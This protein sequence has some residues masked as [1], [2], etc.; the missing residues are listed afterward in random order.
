MTNHERI[1]F[2]GGTGGC[3][4]VAVRQVL[5]KGIPV[6]IYTRKPEESEFQGNPNVILVKGDYT[7]YT[8]Y[9]KSIAG[10]TR[11]FLLV[12]SLSGMPAIK[13]KLAKI[14][15]ASG[16][17]QIVD[18][19]SLTINACAW[20]HVAHQ[21]LGGEEAIDALPERKGRSYVRLRPWRF[22][23]NHFHIKHAI[24][25]T[26][27]IV[28]V[29]EPDV[30]QGWISPND[31]GLLAAIVL[32]DPFEKHADGIYLMVGY[33]YTPAERAQILSK[34]LGKPIVY[35]K[36]SF[37]EQYGIFTNVVGFPHKISYDFAA[38]IYPDPH[39]SP[40]LSLALGREPETLEQW[41]E[42]NKKHF[43]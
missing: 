15:Y 31:I 3:G 5:E 21:H 8:P 6:T 10:H 29:A 4:A 9:E 7:D 24:A 43:E 30:P 1:Y 37:K 39:Y 2:V 18:V 36:W 38:D 42:K 22:M 34:V 20:T 17:Q 32:T 13:E 23:S 28:G 12:A 26:G 16:V 25:A 14:A 33:L 19:S 41:S 27:A 11:L 40:H 35:K